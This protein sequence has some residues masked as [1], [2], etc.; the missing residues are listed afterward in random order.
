VHSRG[1]VRL[2]T[3]PFNTVLRLWLGLEWFAEIFANWWGL[4]SGSWRVVVSERIVVF[5]SSSSPFRM[6]ESVAADGA[7]NGV[8]EVQPAM[9][10]DMLQRLA[11]KSA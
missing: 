1:G 8:D 6:E 10:A 3:R 4:L 5:C 9:D 7:A 11:V 2:E